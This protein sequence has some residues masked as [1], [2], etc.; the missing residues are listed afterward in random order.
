MI[1]RTLQRPLH[2]FL[3]GE[4]LRACCPMVALLCV[5]TNPP[6]LQKMGVFTSYYLDLCGYF[7]VA[8][9][10]TCFLLHQTPEAPLKRT[11]SV[12]RAVHRAVEALPLLWNKGSTEQ[13]RNQRFQETRVPRHTVAEIWVHPLA[14]YFQLLPQ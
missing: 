14:S 1:L 9:L 12:S 6:S 13:P 11:R 10:R 5:P 7:L 4:F 2:V 8:D 3:F